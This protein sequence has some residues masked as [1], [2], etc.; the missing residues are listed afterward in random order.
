MSKERA[1]RRA[2]RLA[3]AEKQKASRARRVARR[4][5]RQAVQRA[6]T[7][8]RRGTGRLHRRSRAERTGILLVPLAAAVAV[9]VLVPGIALRV[10]LTA[11]IVLVLPALV[12]LV[13]GRRS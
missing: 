2:A 5:R 10:A 7:P 3:V 13:L 12:V 4:Q 11:L 8:R 6:L 9:W 1:R